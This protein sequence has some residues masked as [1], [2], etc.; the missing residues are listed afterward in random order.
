MRTSIIST[1]ALA[2]LACVTLLYSAEPAAARTCTQRLDA[3]STRCFALGEDAKIRSCNQ[4]TC[5][6][7]HRACMSNAA[8]GTDRPGADPKGKGGKTGP[9]VRDKRKPRGASLTSPSAGWTAWIQPRSAAGAESAG[10]QVT[11]SG[12]TGGQRVVRD[13]RAR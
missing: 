6:P 3:C 7:Q 13:H 9:I 5:N 1:M 11:M 8:G 12:A 4:R 2:S 10:G